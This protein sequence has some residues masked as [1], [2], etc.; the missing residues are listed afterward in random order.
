MLMVIFS[1]LRARERTDLNSSLSSRLIS[2]WAVQVRGNT[3]VE[4]HWAYELYVT[5]T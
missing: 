3:E 1:S 4:Y 2:R 5:R